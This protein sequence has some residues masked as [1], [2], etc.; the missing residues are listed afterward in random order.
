MYVYNYILIIEKEDIAGRWNLIA[1][2]R[3]VL[4]FLKFGECFLVKEDSLHYN[5]FKL[6]NG[7]RE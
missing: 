5:P 1:Q 6:D 4:I 7:A 3:K 2:V